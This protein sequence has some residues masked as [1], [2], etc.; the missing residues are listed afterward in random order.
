MK[1]VHSGRAWHWFRF[2]FVSIFL[3]FTVPATATVITQ[4]ANNGIAAYGKLSTDTQ[5]LK[6]TCSPLPSH[7]ESSWKA[8]PSS[9]ILK[10]EITSVFKSTHKKNSQF[11]TGRLV[12]KLPLLNFCL[13]NTASQATMHTAFCAR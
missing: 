11:L 12:T 4:L 10:S 13:Q 6:L 1:G 8:S 7:I 2:T 5:E 9:S 3:S